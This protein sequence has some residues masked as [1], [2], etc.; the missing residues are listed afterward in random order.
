MPRK[1]YRFLSAGL[2]LHVLLAILVLLGEERPALAVQTLDVDSI[3]VTFLS[4]SAAN[5]DAG[6]IQKISANTLTISSDV[7]WKLSVAGTASSFSCS[8]SECWQ[9]KPREDVQWR[10][11]G[12]SYASL[13]G[14]SSTVAIGASTVPDSDDI[15]IDYRI[16][17]DWS[18][19]SP[20]TYTYD[21]VRYELSAL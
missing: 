8:G 12:G 10:E 2:A 20:G 9:S 19:D 4:P 7:D 1:P 6:G 17:L 15:I 21:F 18:S 14:T 13:S 3:Q 5:F 11:S 16:V